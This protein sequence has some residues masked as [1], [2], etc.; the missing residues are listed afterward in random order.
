LG[1]NFGKTRSARESIDNNLAEYNI[2]FQLGVIKPFATRYSAS[3][4]VH[5]NL[6]IGIED[7]EWKILW[8]LKEVSTPP[9]KFL[10]K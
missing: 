7:K 1:G 6:E 8:E 9:I 2:G 5:I 10:P 4:S 3:L